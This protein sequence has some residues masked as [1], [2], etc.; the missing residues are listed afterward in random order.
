M[1]IISKYIYAVVLVINCFLCHADS[2]SLER[3]PI[4]NAQIKF[5]RAQVS[6]SIEEIIEVLNTDYIYPEKVDALG[7]E[8]RQLN[9]MR[10]IQYI[11]NKAVFMREVGALL[12]RASRDGYIELLPVKRQFSMGHDLEYQYQQQKSNF[13]FEQVRVL[14]S[15]IGY[16]KINYFFQNKE[17]EAIAKSAFSLLQG[18]KAIIIDLREASEGSMEFAQYLMSYF[19]E[20]RT[21][22]CRM[23]HQRQEKQHEMW[24]IGDIGDMGFKRDYPIFILTSSFATSAAE[25]FS[26][27]L[28]HLNKAVI[29]GEQT[30]G[31]ANWSQEII[32]NDWLMMKLPV[33][34]PVNPVTQ[35]NWE[36]KGVIPDNKTEASSSFTLAY[37]LAKA[38]I[39]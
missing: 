22:L 23:I 39:D 34:I 18:T 17:A 4:E 35:S 30:M 28:K 20:P 19:I 37:K 24:S 29:V 15:N 3:E 6:Q 10:A 27:T 13:G 25:F 2:K 16:L 32:V 12:R 26:Y 8:L 14:E 38:S 9:R 31:V 5:T 11:N 33:A 21:L 1:K 36:D 7:K